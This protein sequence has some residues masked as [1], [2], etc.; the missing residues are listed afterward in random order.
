[1]TRR[2]PYRRHLLPPWAQHAVALAGFLLIAAVLNW[3]MP[4]ILE[5]MAR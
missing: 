2:N 5:G 3:A 1:M 4:L